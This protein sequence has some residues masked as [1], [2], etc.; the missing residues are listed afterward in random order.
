MITKWEYIGCWYKDL[1]QKGKEGWEAYAVVLQNGWYYF[2][3]RPL[4]ENNEHT[5]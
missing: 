4:K 2:L 3:K 5:V 1:D